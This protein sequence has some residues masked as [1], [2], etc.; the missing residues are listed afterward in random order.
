MLLVDDDQSEFF[1]RG[2]RCR[3]RADKDAD[4]PSDTLAHVCSR[5]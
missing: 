1:K 3:A 5:C 4:I 2:K